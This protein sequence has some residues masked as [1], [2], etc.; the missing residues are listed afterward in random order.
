MAGI[1]L[2]TAEEKLQLWLEADERLAS[3]QAV[4]FGDRT[5][6]RA[7]TQA[8][9]QYWDQWCKRLARRASGGGIGRVTHG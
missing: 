3:G 8:K 6:T 2:Q 1:D 7:E 4:T 5:I 9:I